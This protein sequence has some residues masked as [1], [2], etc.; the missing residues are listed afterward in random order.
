[1]P[2]ME[3]NGEPGVVTIRLFG[4]LG[5]LMREKGLPPRS[6]QWVPRE[7]RTG[8]EI[9]AEIGLPVEKIEAAFRNGRIQSLEEKVFPGDRV[10]FVPRGTPGP[11][12][13]LLGMVG[14]KKPPRP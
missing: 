9:A 4:F 11:Y 6:E 1:M 14:G 5:A 2:P 13:V 7:G 10:A 3:E 12:R 8:L